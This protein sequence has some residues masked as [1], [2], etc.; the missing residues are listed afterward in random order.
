MKKYLWVL[1]VASFLNAYEAPVS[2]FGLLKT[3]YASSLYSVYVP[4]VGYLYCS[5]F[6]VQAPI[7]TNDEMP[8]QIDNRRALEMRYHAKNF[9]LRTL[10]LEQKY[11]LGYTDG[12]CL[13]Q[14][15]AHL[16]NATMIKEG[17]AVARS[18]PKLKGDA[19][20]KDE[21]GILESIARKERKG[22]W[23]DYE[24]EMLCLKR[25]AR[26]RPAEPQKGF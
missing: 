17:F 4:Q 12:Y 5:L 14:D 7:Y 18:L 20:L 25:I 23:G 13:V 10:Q 24:K 15:G 19:V 21:L 16:Y 1:C 9:T 22:L 11:R 26:V 3:V 8:C 2:F 6:G